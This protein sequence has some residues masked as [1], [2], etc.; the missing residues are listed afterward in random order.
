MN[1]IAAGPFSSVVYKGERGK[2]R[3]KIYAIICNT[4][5]DMYDIHIY[6]DTIF[7]PYQDLLY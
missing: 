6:I 5:I 4:L 7:S 1:P 2:P 3:S